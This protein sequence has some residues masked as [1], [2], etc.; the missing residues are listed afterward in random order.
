MFER[1]TEGDRNIFVGNCRQSLEKLIGLGTQVSNDTI[2]FIFSTVESDTTYSKLEK[3]INLY[4][5][6]ESVKAA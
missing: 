6:L 5:K 2:G 3:V 1:Y 4:N